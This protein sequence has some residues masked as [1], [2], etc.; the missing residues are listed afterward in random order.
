VTTSIPDSA[1]TLTYTYD[2]LGSIEI[3]YGTALIDTYPWTD[4]VGHCT[5]ARLLLILPMI[6]AAS[7][8]DGSIEVDNL[9]VRSHRGCQIGTSYCVAAPNST[10][11]VGTLEV[12]GSIFTVE[13]D[14]LLVATG[15][16]PFTFNYFFFG[17]NQINTPSFAGSV[18]TLSVTGDP[19]GRWVGP[20]QVQ[21]ATGDGYVELRL[22]LGAFPTMMGPV[23]VHPGETWN[24]Q[25][26]FRDDPGSS[27]MPANFTD[28]VS[29]TFQ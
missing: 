12:Y 4:G 7:G 8:C 9:A 2:T 25:N 24:F 21:R 28:A 16:P 20:G 22:D 18:G 6:D 27:A 13:E 14:L 1:Q 3:H 26:W 29:I 10:G 17:A 19:V 15:L 11:F 23:V 5:L